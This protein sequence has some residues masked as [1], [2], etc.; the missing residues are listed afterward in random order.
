MK[1]EYYQQQQLRLPQQGA[2][3]IAQATQD[4]IIVYQAFNPAIAQYAVANQRFGGSH[5]SFARMTWIKPNFMWMMYRA[6]WASKPNQERILAITLKK[7]GFDEILRQAVFSSFKA[8]R[9]STK[10]EWQQALTQSS[11]RLQWDPDHAP[12]GDKLQRRA[13]Q[14]G[15]KGSILQQLNN[16][17]IIQIDDITP[18][19]LQQKQNIG[20]PDLRV[21]TEDVVD[22]SNH[23]AIVQN[24][25]LDDKL[26]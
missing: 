21:P 11:V 14:L 4:N 17:W 16:E 23:P 20:T 2:H 18:F 10:E 25:L 6:G 15:L 24:I 19:V 26:T 13:I 7:E 8:A 3:I 5:Y 1:T 12:N 22:Y 9:Y